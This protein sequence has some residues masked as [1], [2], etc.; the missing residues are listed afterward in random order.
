MGEGVRCQRAIELRT[1]TSNVRLQVVSPTRLPLRR[2]AFFLGSLATLRVAIHGFVDKR[3]RFGGAEASDLCALMFS[4]YSLRGY[5][6]RGLQSLIEGAEYKPPLWYVGVA[7][8]FAPAESLAYGPLLLTNAVALAL[9]LGAAWSLGVRLGQARA[10]FL[11]V[12]IVASL[13]AIAGRVTIL[14]IE[15]WH[16]AL[17]GWSIVLLLRIRGANSTR[18]QAMLLGVTVGAG[19]LMKWNFIAVLMG[20]VLLET[21]WALRSGPSGALWRRRLTQA[22]AVSTGLFLLWF[23]PFAQVDRISSGAGSHPTH[24]ALLSS[25]SLLAF[26]TWTIQGLGWAGL[27]L[28]FLAVLGA[29][30]GRQQASKESA[31]GCSPSLL[32]VASGVGLVVVHWLLP[33]KEPRYLLPA[34]WS[35]SLLLSIHVAALWSR[36]RWG[37]VLCV[38]G[39]TC[40]LLSS[41]ALPWLGGNS[42]E[43]SDFPIR[44]LRLSTD[45]SDHGVDA[46]VRHRSIQGT[47]RPHV[48]FSLEGPRQGELLTMINWELYGR[49]T[50]PVISLPSFVPLIAAEPSENLRVATH[51]ITNR[52]LEEDEL[53]VIEAQGFARV[54]TTE[55]RFPGPRLWSLWSRE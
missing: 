44:E 29:L 55:L 33:H 13:P 27:F 46:L 2:A 53:R 47:T 5:G 18:G 17:L 1:R 24:G 34:A 41:F 14:G 19:M 30:L 7:A 6:G 12:L 50:K 9:A 36:G 23:L 32:L 3:P 40:L 38:V 16:M 25:E 28:L 52:V 10:G 48:L 11:A 20:P 42:T 15:P 8:L 22:G 54:I 21:V 49:N 51:L 43:D 45:P 26:P 4:H 37:Q 39:V 31:R 35:L